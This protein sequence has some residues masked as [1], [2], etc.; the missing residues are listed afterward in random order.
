MNV[1]L[2]WQVGYLLLLQSSQDT[3]SSFPAL[4][5]SLWQKH[6]TLQQL[7]PEIYDK[8]DDIYQTYCSNLFT[9]ADS[10]KQY[11]LPLFFHQFM[12]TCMA[13][14]RLCKNLRFCLVSRKTG[15]DCPK[16]TVV[17]L[18]PARNEASHS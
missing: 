5:T 4:P 6:T 9:Y 2:Q 15:I 11:Y 12:Y 8:T 1:I 10:C 17:V 3:C 18:N 7:K 14:M 13:A 16:R